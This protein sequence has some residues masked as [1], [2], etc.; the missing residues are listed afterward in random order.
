MVRAIF[1]VWNKIP[2]NI[3]YELVEELLS[4]DTSKKKLGLLILDAIIVN[5]FLPKNPEFNSRFKQHLVKWLTLDEKRDLTRSCA[6]LCGSI[7]IRESDPE[8]EKLVCDAL[9]MWYNRKKIDVFVDLLYEVAI[10]HTAVLTTFA[11]T[12]LSLLTGLY[13]GLKVIESNRTKLI[14]NNVFMV[15]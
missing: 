4:P 5:G 13:G 15:Y 2:L 9:Q 11:T 7:L 8:F 12:N 1:S 14:V 6:A 10:R 3:P